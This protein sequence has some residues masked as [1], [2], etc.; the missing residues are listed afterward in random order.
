VPAS[1]FGEGLKA[2]EKEKRKEK[3]FYIF[4][5]EGRKALAYHVH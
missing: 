3:S 4:L 5:L 1:F 2:F